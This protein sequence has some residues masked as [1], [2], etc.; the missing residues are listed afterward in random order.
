MPI[1]Y[2]SVLRKAIFLNQ[3][4]GVL[5]E[6]VSPALQIT[7]SIVECHQMQLLV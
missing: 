6:Q 5:D 7:G 1:E 3:A 4:E 2:Y